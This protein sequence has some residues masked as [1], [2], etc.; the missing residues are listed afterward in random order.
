MPAGMLLGVPVI[1]K[2]EPTETKPSTP[3]TNGREGDGVGDGRGRFGHLRPD[4]KNSTQTQIAGVGYGKTG[5]NR[6]AGRR[7]RL[8]QVDRRNSAGRA[9]HGKHN[10]KENA[11]DRVE[12]GAARSLGLG[13][14]EQTMDIID[15]GRRN[16]KSANPTHRGRDADLR[17]A[18]GQHCVLEAT[19]LS[20]LE[21]HRGCRSRLEAATKVVPLPTLLVALSAAWMLACKVAGVVL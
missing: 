3:G 17:V 8:R 20:A 2:Y 12:V 19:G 7:D 6:D 13:D 4:G 10:I 15:R 16:V 5:I 1:P 11:A 14:T 9:N 21:S 18:V